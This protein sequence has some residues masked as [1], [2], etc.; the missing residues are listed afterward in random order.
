MTQQI[1]IKSLCSFS[2]DTL[3]RLLLS[4]THLKPVQAKK[5]GVYDYNHASKEQWSMS[6][7]IVCK[8]LDELKRR[9]LVENHP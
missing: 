9:G 2:E 3:L 4:G 1:H 5:V 6:Q 7:H 8:R